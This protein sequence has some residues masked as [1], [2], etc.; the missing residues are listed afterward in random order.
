EARW[1]RRRDLPGQERLVEDL[2][3]RHLVTPLAPQPSGHALRERV[4]ARVLDAEPAGGRW[5]WCRLCELGVHHAREL[6]QLLRR[7][8][9]ERSEP[10]LRSIVGVRAL[11]ITLLPVDI[12][13]GAAS[14]ARESFGGK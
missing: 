4:R 14:S 10:R 1:W 9:G 2:A 5:R 7:H 12:V 11:V 13:H 3:R 6:R 8:R